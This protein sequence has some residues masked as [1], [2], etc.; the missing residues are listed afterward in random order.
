MTHINPPTSLCLFSISLNVWLNRIFFYYYCVKFFLVNQ[1]RLVIVVL[2]LLHDISLS[3]KLTFYLL[4]DVLK[5]SSKND[6]I[7]VFIETFNFFTNFDKCDFD[8]GVFSEGDVVIKQIT[9]LSSDEIILNMR[10]VVTKK[11]E[12]SIFVEV[13]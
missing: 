5:I 4:F 2:Y 12:C 13:F 1:I 3:W 9:R 11:D 8:I 7:F 10:C 6:S